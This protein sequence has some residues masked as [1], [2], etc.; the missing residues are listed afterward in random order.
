MPVQK[1]LKTNTSVPLKESIKLKESNNIVAGNS[2]IRTWLGGVSLE[3]PAPIPAEALVTGERQVEF[4]VQQQVHPALQDG[5]FVQIVRITIHITWDSNLLLLLD[6]DLF[7]E[8]QVSPN[9]T[10]MSKTAENLYQSYRSTL[11]NLLTA[12]GHQPPLPNTL[13]EV[14]S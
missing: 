6:I 8:H 1:T 14:E 2:Q 9:S 4:R 7:A 10:T 3:C 5:A 11:Q 13:S 12:A